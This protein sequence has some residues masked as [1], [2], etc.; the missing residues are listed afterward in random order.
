M[1]LLKD[2]L[3]DLKDLF[4]NNKSSMLT[5]INALNTQMTIS[6][7][8]KNNTFKKLR[9]DLSAKNKPSPNGNISY[10]IDSKVEAVVA[11]TPHTLQDRVKAH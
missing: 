11:L 4:N 5:G 6:K 7:N 9:K 8:N 1:Q 10:L 2:N 3:Q